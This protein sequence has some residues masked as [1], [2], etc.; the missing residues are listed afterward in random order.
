MKADGVRDLD[1]I[2]EGDT[3]S[4][5]GAML[6][7]LGIGGAC[8]VF[9]FMA[10][11]GKRTR[12]VT[13]KTDPLAQFVKAGESDKK[14]LDKA[15]ADKSRRSELNAGDVTFPGLLS[16]QDNPTTALAAVRTVQTAALDLS[17]R[18]PPPA[19]DRLSVEPLPAQDV[20]QQSPLTSRPRDELTRVVAERSE[21]AFAGGTK[22]PSGKEGG[23]QLQVSS[24][25]TEKEASTFSEQLR[26]RGHKAYVLAAEVP[27]R[28]TWYRVR[29]GPFATQQ[30]AINYRSTFE[31][32]EH[33]VPFVVPPNKTLPQH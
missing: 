13:P 8:V 24:F 29:V 3:A 12:E 10:W 4:S 23:Y 11:S 6:T 30:S 9:A 7:F 32:K 27:G 2:Q 16:D 14:A 21:H 31:G 22:A 25:R 1:L 28:G 26:A 33:V 20:M 5:R 18:Q 19:G 15:S 17:E